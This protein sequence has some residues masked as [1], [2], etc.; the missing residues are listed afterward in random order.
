MAIQNGGSIRIDSLLPAGQIRELDTFD[1]AP[2]AN[3]VTVV[4]EISRSQFKEILENTVSRAVEG[5]T[6]GGTGRFAQVCGFSFE[7]SESGTAQV[8]NPDGSVRV[9]GARVQR[10]VLDDGDVI[11]GGGGV[12]SGPDLTVA[13]VD[14]LARGGDEYPFRGAPFTVLGVSYQQALANYI[15]FPA[16]LDGTVTAADYPESGEGRVK[17]LP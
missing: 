3:M 8:L 10:V 13:T 9:P 7:W 5:D 12:M 2:F 14:F 1:M 15:Q 11:V 4:E 6:D 16:D 17:R